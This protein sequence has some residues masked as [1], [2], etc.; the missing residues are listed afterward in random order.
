MV[1]TFLLIFMLFLGL[2]FIIA[3]IWALKNSNLTD[4]EKPR[5]VVKKDY[6]DNN[7]KED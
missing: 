7:M 3:L 4:S 2:I 5:H 6:D 1:D